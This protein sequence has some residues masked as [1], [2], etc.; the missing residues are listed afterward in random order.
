VTIFEPGA[1]RVV[2]HFAA[3]GAIA[4]LALSPNGRWV[5]GGSQDATL[6]GWNVRD[7][8]DF[9]MSGFPKTVSRL[10]F[11][12]SGR[13]L[14]CDGGDAVVCWDFSGSGPTGRQAV[15]A[16][17]LSADITALA[18]GPSNGAATVLAAG[19]AAGDIASWRLGPQLRPGQRI[20]PS[21]TVA[22]DDP[23]SAVVAVG[24]RIISGHRSGVV[25]CFN[26]SA[27]G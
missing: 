14:C 17:G 1:H 20:R 8:S 7:G 25:R 3:P 24:N 19:D 9:A 10:A 21:W 27:R 4:G 11:E 16:E 6:H 26:R 13:W 23:V 12:S 18:W 2:D 15:L 5:V 22:T